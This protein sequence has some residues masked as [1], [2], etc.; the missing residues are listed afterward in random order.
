MMP[1]EGEVN[2]VR[3]HSQDLLDAAD[4]VEINQVIGWLGVVEVEI[5]DLD[6][7]DGMV[8]CR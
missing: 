4:K 3:I 5:R 8:V 1:K 6:S 7:M 2:N